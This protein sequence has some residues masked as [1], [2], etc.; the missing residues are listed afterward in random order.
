MNAPIIDLP[1]SLT[2][3]TILIVDDEAANRKLL[4]AMLKPEGYLTVSVANG[5]EAIA[6]IARAPP[7]LILLDIMMPGMDGYQV[8][9]ILKSDAQTSSIPVIMVTA[10]RGPQRARSRA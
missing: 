4:E 10:P 8:A 7:D 9:R 2:A 1:V 5:E 3:A 6:A